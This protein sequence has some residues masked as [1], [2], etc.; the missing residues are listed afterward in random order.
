MYNMDDVKSFNE[1]MWNKLNQKD[2]LHDHF[3]FFDHT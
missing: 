2:I 1:T 3:F